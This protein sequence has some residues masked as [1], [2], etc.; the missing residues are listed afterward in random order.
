M[1]SVLAVKALVRKPVG[2]GFVQALGVVTAV[3]IVG[4]AFVVVG[5]ALG[6]RFAV[7]VGFVSGIVLAFV[8][9]YFDPSL[10]ERSEVEALDLPIM[11]EIPK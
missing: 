3:V 11:G 8:A 10:R 1:C 2:T 6:A 4:V 7:T 9:H 5:S